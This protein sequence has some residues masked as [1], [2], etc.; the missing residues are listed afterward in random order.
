[1]NNDELLDLISGPLKLPTEDPRAMETP[2]SALF[3][4]SD[5]VSEKSFH[6][7]QNVYFSLLFVVFWTGFSLAGS[8]AAAIGGDPVVSIIALLLGISGLYTARIIIFNYRFFDYFYNRYSA[9]KLVRDGNP[10]LYVPKGNSP[11]ER[12]LNHLRSN[13]QPFSKLLVAHPESIQF[14][15]I[16]RGR[17]GGASQFDAYIGIPA[18]SPVLKM[19]DIPPKL[20]K[21]GY[22]L[23]IKVLDTSPT[24]KEIRILEDT[25]Q[26][27]TALT[28]LPPRVVVLHEGGDGNLPDDLYRHLTEEGASAPC[29]KGNYPY[30]VQVVSGVEGAYD[31]V[32]LISSEG[33]P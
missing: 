9:I 15:A 25:V 28:C 22:A 19:G 29:K 7:R 17:S 21:R 23:F 27:V 33:L 8:V 32:P 5:Q 26:D 20:I 24:L 14:A 11:V 12:Y 16:M 2:M 30:N 3:N 4:L 31:M 1:M 18:N 10:N 6:V 13:Y